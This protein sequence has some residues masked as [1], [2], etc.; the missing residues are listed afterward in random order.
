MEGVA[1]LGDLVSS[2]TSGD[3]RSVHEQV[4]AALATVNE[5]FA[6]MSPLVV[7]VGDEHQGVFDSLGT[8]LTATLRLRLLLLP[9][10]DVRHGLGVGAMT[11]LQERPLIQDGPAWWAARAAIEEVERLAA[12]AGTGGARTLLADVPAVNAALL[13][14]D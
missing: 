3:R 11:V 8:A 4:V 9:E 13:G 12:D 7:T 6:P 5:E 2:R 1:V 14:R 10:V